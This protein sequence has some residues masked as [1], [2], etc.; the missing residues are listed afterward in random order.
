[1][2][3]RKFLHFATW[4]TS[5]QFPASENEFLT[6]ARCSDLD[7]YHN[8]SGYPVEVQYYR[9]TKIIL[10]VL[11]EIKARMGLISKDSDVLSL[12]SAHLTALQASLPRT[13]I[14]PVDALLVLKG[15]ILRNFTYDIRSKGCIMRF[16]ASV[17]VEEFQGTLVDRELLFPRTG[18]RDLPE[19][20]SFET[21][22]DL[23]L[24]YH[25]KET[26]VPYSSQLALLYTRKEIMNKGKISRNC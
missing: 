21:C 13:V 23:F 3:R 15:D 2:V 24:Q 5:R 1:M 18:S 8:T 4:E 10:T 12:E 25:F 11:A 19:E 22:F 17:V 9:D 26:C 14:V 16:S 6:A 7:I 20:L